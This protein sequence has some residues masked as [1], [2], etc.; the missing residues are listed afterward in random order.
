MS[1]SPTFQRNLH[2]SIETEAQ[3]SEMSVCRFAQR[4]DIF[5]VHPIWELL[6]GEYFKILC[7]TPGVVKESS[8]KSDNRR[9][10]VWSGNG[11]RGR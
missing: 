7:K 6:I 9:G 3:S 5:G 2:L 4:S 11:A 8:G 1:L 10:C